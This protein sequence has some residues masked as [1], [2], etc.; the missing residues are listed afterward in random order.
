[1]PI[2][3]TVCL[4]L[5]RFGGRA[6]RAGSAL[7]AGRDLP[8]GAPARRAPSLPAG[9]RSASGRRA[10]SASRSRVGGAEHALERRGPRRAAR[11]RSRRR[12]AHDYALRARRRRALPDPRS[13]AGSPTG[14]RG[15]SRGRR[16]GAFDVDRRRPGSPP[17]LARPRHLRA[18][19]RHVHA[20]GDVRRRRSRTSRELR[21]L[22]VTAIELMPV[23]EFPGRRGWGYDGVYLSRRA[24]RLRRAR[25][26]FAAA[27]RR[28]PRRAASRSIL[29]VVY[30]H[31]GA[32]GEHGARGVRPLLHRRSTRR[33]GARRS[34]STTRT[35][36]PVREWVLQSRRGL[37][38]RLPR[39]RPA[40]RRHPRDLRLE[41]RAPRRRDR[42][43]VHAASPR[44]LVIAESG[45]NDPQGHAPAARTAAGAAT[46][47]GP[48]TSTTPCASLLTGDARGLLRGVRRGR[49]PRQGV[50]PP[51]RPRRQLLDVPPPALRGARPRTSPPERFVV[52]SANHDQVGNRALGDRLP[53]EVAPARR[54]LHAAVTVHADAVHGR[55]VRRARAVPVLHRPHRRGDRDRHPRGAPARVRRVRRVRR[56]GGPRPAGPGDVRALQAHARGRPRRCASCTR[57][58]LAARRELPAG[59]ADEIAFDEDAGWLRVRRGASRAGRELRRR[60]TVHVPLEQPASVARRHARRRRS[61]A[62]T[63]C[64]PPLAGALVAMSEVWPGRPFPLGA[65]LGRRGHELLAVLR[66]RRARRAV[67]VRRRRQRGARRR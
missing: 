52:F 59:D 33:S 9:R 30:N 27:R 24:V 54:V 57:E 37:G 64:C 44:A 39:R 11:R 21:E 15:P 23:A 26:G 49:R 5:R 20:G 53:A 6:E 42:R 34:T 47:R 56:R 13:A 62:A 38:P 1:M 61:S 3:Q 31:V 43:R 63:S 35:R 2:R 48:T 50:P 46:P 25:T 45:L 67:P 7:D 22:G 32:S 19:R 16:P 18:A 55:G 17:A 60:E 28:R 10:P 14:L 12:R 58:L 51:A 66:E 8:L 40:P 36:D 29:D 65:D 4:R 41:R